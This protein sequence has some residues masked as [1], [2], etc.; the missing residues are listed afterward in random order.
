MNKISANV[1]GSGLLFCALANPANAAVTLYTDM[2]D[3]QAATSGVSFT[4][5]FDDA[6]LECGLTYVSDVGYIASGR[7]NDR[8]TRSGAESTT[9]QWVMPVDA[10]GGIWDLS[11]GGPG[12]GLALTA[13]VYAGG[14]V[15]IHE[16]PNTTVG[17]FIGFV[18]DE[19][20]NKLII[21]A[22]TQSGV[23]ETYALDDLVWTE[24]AK[25][26]AIDDC[27]TEIP[28]RMNGACSLNNDI[29]LL[30]RNC[31]YQAEN[32]GDYVSCVVKGLKSL[33]RAG[34]IS[35]RELGA[36]TSCAARSDGGKKD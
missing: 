35:G 1:L 9:L 13:E 34:A 24:A 23:A 21:R 33:R 2:T 26:I 15:S 12:Q 31:D 11:P 30:D 20:I 28:N 6:T 8:V 14:M 36:M 16:I 25:T 7:F 4:E 19:P 5:K 22:G 27:D 32:H 29:S 3:W 10:V 17:S 18:S